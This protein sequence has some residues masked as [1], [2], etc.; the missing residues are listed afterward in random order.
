PTRAATGGGRERA[1]EEYVVA[2][3]PVRAGGAE[4]ADA[5]VDGRAEDG[6]SLVAAQGRPV[7]EAEPHAA[8]A[9][10]RHLESA[11]SQHARL[12]TVY[13]R[14]G[15][16]GAS[17]SQRKLSAR[18]MLP[19]PVYTARS[20]YGQSGLV[21]MGAVF[22]LRVARMRAGARPLPTHASSASIGSNRS[23]PSPPEQ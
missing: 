10:G 8:E 17:A 23:G 16:A 21:R 15:P 13:C 19:L 18:S 4:D 14:R 20:G 12:H 5:A 1:A 2:E 6:E 11:R 22:V 7:G 9:E 3:R